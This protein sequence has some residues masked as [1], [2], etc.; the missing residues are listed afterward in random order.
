M[1]RNSFKNK[2]VLPTIGVLIIL[3]VVLISYA[4][5]EFLSFSNALINEKVAANVN[6]LKFYLNDSKENSKGAAVSMALNPEV[7][8]TVKKRNREEILKIF[9]SMSEFYRVTYFAITDE[10]GVVLARTHE[11]DNFGDDLTRQQNIK[12][13]LKG[14]VS[15]Y[16]E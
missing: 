4:T 14:K 11:P 7:I 9:N 16:F 3:A 8:K 2:I 13:A 1:F 15:S 10:R 6:S 12:D 5:K